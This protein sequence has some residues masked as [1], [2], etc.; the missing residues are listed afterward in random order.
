[1]MARQGI[2]RL[3]MALLSYTLAGTVKTSF[4]ATS[5]SAL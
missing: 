2:D 4:T 5:V 3:I 1:M